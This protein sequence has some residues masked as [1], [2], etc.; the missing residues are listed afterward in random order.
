MSAEAKV[1]VVDDE[2]AI[3]RALS[4]ALTARGYR[5]EVARDGHEALERA[6]TT[7]PDLIVLD[8]GLPD[9]DGIE[10]VRRLRE[11]SDVPV[12]VLT[13]EGADDV[14]VTALDEGADDYVSKP[15]SID[16]LMARVRVALR[17]GPAEAEAP[18]TFASGG[19]ILDFGAHTATL[20]GATVHL[21]PTEWRLLAELARHLGR[22]VP[23][24]ELLKAVWGPNY[25]GEHHYLRVFANQI[26]RKIEADPAQPRHLINEPGLGYRLVP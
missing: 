8:L 16:E 19:L 21:T 18:Q 17:R 23:H 22:V 3:V 24:E 26:R 4:A 15:F 6:A 20:N 12:V 11:W 5:V 9:I 2:H 14:K 7:A 1:L 25:G 10:V 13:A